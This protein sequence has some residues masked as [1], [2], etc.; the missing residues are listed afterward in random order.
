MPGTNPARPD[1][2]GLRGRVEIWA[3]RGT[4][5]FDHQDLQNIVL[6]QGFSEI[7]KSISVVSPVTKPRII[8]RM[9]VGDQG[10]VPADSTVPKTPTRDMTGLF[11]EIY[12]KDCES[13]EL[14]TSGAENSC[15]FVT[16]FS[17]AEVQMSAYANPSQPRINEVGL[18]LIDPVASSGLVR[19]PVT[20][21]DLPRR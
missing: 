13:R 2:V 17:A 1:H 12:R 10:T 3:F 5:L 4:E 16:T 8:A 9:C 7:I 21:P 18:V 19:P 11:H 14:T 15:K 6:N 20:A